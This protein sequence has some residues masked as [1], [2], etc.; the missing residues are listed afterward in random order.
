MDWCNGRLPNS[1]GSTHLRLRA[2]A[3]IALNLL[4]VL[5]AWSDTSSQVAITHVTV[6]D[7]RDGSAR[8]DMTV[9]ILGNRISVVASSKNT[10]LPQQ[11]IVINGQGE[12][13]IP[14]LW[15]MHIHTDGDG[16]RSDCYSPLA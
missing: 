3:V 13:L 9:L 5:R 10:P 4:A 7:V 15:D 14:G 8:S 11:V 2:I 6:L 16:R 1:N 12:F